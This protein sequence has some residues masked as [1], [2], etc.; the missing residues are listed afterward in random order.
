T[1][2]HPLLAYQIRNNVRLHKARLYCVNSYPIK[3]RRQATLFAQVPA[4][5]EMHAVSFLGGDDGVGDALG[6]DARNALLAMRQKLAG[7]ENVVVIFG[8]ELRGGS[9]R[10]A[11]RLAAKL[12]ATIVCL[13]DYANSR[14]AADMGLYPNLL[15]GYAAIGSDSGLARGW[16]AEWPAAAG[17]KIEQMFAAAH[18]DKLKALYCVGSNPVVRYNVDPFALQNTFLVV[19]ELFM[20]ETASLAN[21]VLPAACAYEKAGTFTNTC[22]D[23]QL[24]KKAG[25]LTG[26]KPDFEIIVEVADRMGYDIRKLVPFGG[27]MRADMGESRGAQSG[28]ADRHA[29]WLEANNLEPK[30]SPIDPMAL[31][32]EI[33]RL[34]PGYDV[35]RLNLAAGNDVHTGA[36]ELGV[37]RLDT[38]PDTIVPSEDTLFTS[39]TLGR[40]SATLQSVMENRR[41]FPADKEAAL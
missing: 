32:D 33:Q 24:L 34:V 1:D 41:K 17:L 9:V 3:L 36:L 38:D 28:E 4:G 19:H 11:V 37:G 25:D 35:S 23:L 27:A 22:G 8:A 29:V 10:A 7:E 5:T 31:L 40:Y 13:G 30:L 6:A 18:D 12:K 14:G 26:T 39:G 21:V 20:T 15:P 2:Q 16:N